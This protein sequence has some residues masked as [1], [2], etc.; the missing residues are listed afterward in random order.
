MNTKYCNYL[1][2]AEKKRWEEGSMT[3]QQFKRAIAHNLF[4]KSSEQNRD[5]YKN[6]K[7]LFADP[8]NQ[9][10]QQLDIEQLRKLVQ[11]ING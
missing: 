8:D 4:L 9:L 5:N 1:T 7:K 10:Y 11:P 2:A 6:N 3:F